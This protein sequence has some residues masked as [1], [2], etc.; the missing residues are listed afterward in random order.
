[1]WKPLA[2]FNTKEISGLREDAL[3]GSFLATAPD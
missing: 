1:M 3:S 2:R